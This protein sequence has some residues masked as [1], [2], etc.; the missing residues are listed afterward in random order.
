MAIKRNLDGLPS[1]SSSGGSPPD[2]APRFGP[3]LAEAWKAAMG[4][5]ERKP[6]ALPGSRMRASWAAKCARQTQYEL[7]LDEAYA[8][9]ERA[10]TLED[11][12]LVVEA[13]AMVDRCQPSNPTTIAGYWTFGLGTA[14]HEMFQEIIVRDAA[15]LWPGASVRIEPKVDLSVIGLAG[16]AHTDAVIEW[17]AHVFVTEPEPGLII[18]E[19][20][21]PKRIAIELKSINGF[22]FKMAIGCRGDAEGPRDSAIVQGALNALA[23]DVDELVIINLSLESVSPREAQKMGWDE[24]EEWRRFTAEWTFTRE[25]FEPI[26]R[27]EVKRMNNILTTH[28]AGLLVPR[29]VPGTPPGARITDPSRGQWTVERDGSILDVGTTWQC[30]YCNFRD[31]CTNDGPGDV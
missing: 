14:V 27:A 17:P 23:L 26:A 11:E 6:H 21:P 7:M 20:H 25:E 29:R 22:G 16:S 4:R 12:D 19:D 5:E 24:S 18:G 10:T 30:G 3:V 28:D 31:R 9:L 2:S 1:T 8:A 13:Q 15:T